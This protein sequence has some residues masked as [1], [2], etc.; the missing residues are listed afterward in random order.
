MAVHPALTR[1]IFVRI[2][3]DQP[4]LTYYYLYLYK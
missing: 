3:V 4:D 2:E 1:Y